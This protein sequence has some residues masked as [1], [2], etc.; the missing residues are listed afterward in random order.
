MQIDCPHCGFSG[1]LPSAHRGAVICPSCLVRIDP[2]L[3]RAAASGHR[4]R[5][6]RE[7][8][9]AALY[10]GVGIGSVAEGLVWGIAFIV[11]RAQGVT[12]WGAFDALLLGAA[13]MTVGVP[14][15][16]TGVFL[17]HRGTARWRGRAASTADAAILTLALL[18]GVLALPF[19]IA[20]ALPYLLG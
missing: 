11:A 13:A 6:A 12:F 4:G 16:V 10:C 3:T 7:V 2:A 1:A 9:A 20:F 17:V 15:L 19:C 18:I 8:W 5:V 14:L